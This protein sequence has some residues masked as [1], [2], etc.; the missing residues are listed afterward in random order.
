MQVPFVKG[1][2][3]FFAIYEFLNDVIYIFV[4]FLAVSS[5]ICIFT[6]AFPDFIKSNLLKIS[7]FTL[8]VL[9]S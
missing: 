7:L 2:N 5:A 9:L 6:L 3:I 1:T 8:L 4:Y